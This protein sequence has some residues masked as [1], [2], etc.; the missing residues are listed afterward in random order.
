[1]MGFVTDLSAADPFVGEPGAEGSGSVDGL[2]GADRAG[3]VDGERSGDLLALER[4]RCRVDHEVLV[5][6]GRWDASSIWSADG[7]SSGAATAPS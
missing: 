7:S 2:L 5:Q 3:M 6:L 4:V 1:M